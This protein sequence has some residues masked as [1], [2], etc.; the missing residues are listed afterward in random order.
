MTRTLPKLG[1]VVFLADTMGWER[2]L[3][4]ARESGFEGIEIPVSRTLH[5]DKTSQSTLA[6]IKRCMAD[7]GLEVIGSNAVFPFGEGYQ[8]LSPNPADRRRAVEYLYRVI[9][10]NAELGGRIVT[11]GSPHARSI[12][13]GVS[14]DD[15]WKFAIEVFRDWAAYCAPRGQII[16]LE[17]LN[18]YES[19]IG[20]TMDE[21]SRL[22]AA[23]G[24][25]A[26]GLTPDTYHGNI[27]ED[28]I[29]GAIERN[30]RNI[31]NFHM[32]DS[33]RQPPGQGN[34]DFYRTLKA[35]VD[36]GYNGYLSE[37][38]MEV[39]IGVPVRQ[40][41]AEALKSGRDYLAQ[42]LADVAGAGA[43]Q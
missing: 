1:V 2:T 25:P 17:V 26:F 38:L 23:V 35:L 3:A 29:V 18:R 37:E 19:N 22:I 27:D 7:N 13:A 30:V 5:P 10:N 28:P 15:G 6:N 36:N 34:Y 8:M 41:F 4:W 32:G 9:D 21:G 33:N 43:A 39:Y 16:S 20:L 24:S 42:V 12:P 14:Y 31:V 40:P 11:I